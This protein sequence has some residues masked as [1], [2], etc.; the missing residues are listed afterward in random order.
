MQKARQSKCGKNEHVYILNEAVEMTEM[1]YGVISIMIIKWL[2]T[3]A[4]TASISEWLNIWR[5]NSLGWKTQAH[6]TNEHIASW[7]AMKVH[8]IKFKSRIW[9]SS[10]DE[11]HADSRHN[12]S[13]LCRI[14]TAS[15]SLFLFISRSDPNQKLFSLATYLFNCV[16]IICMVNRWTMRIDGEKCNHRSSSSIVVI[17]SQCH[18]FWLLY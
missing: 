9:N 3:F 16:I 2:C 5:I 7:N 11:Y 17:R 4:R 13:N 15:G 10:I 12:R 1:I 18:A 8:F 14:S 6:R